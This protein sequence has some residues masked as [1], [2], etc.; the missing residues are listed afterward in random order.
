M[1]NKEIVTGIALMMAKLVLYLKRT[2]NITCGNK[3]KASKL[4]NYFQE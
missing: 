1:G 3:A 4:I 2:K